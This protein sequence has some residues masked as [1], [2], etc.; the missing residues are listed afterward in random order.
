M[1]S[2]QYPTSGYHVQQERPEAPPSL[3][4]AVKLMYAGAVLSGLSFIIGLATTGRMRQA[5]IKASS[6]PLTNTQLHTAEVGGVVVIVIWGVLGVLL[7]LWM[8]SENGRG[9]SWS[10]IVAGFLF[11]FNTLD[12][13]FALIRPA[14]IGSKIFDILVWLVGLGATIYLRRPDATRY[15][16]QSKP[17]TEPGPSPPNFLPTDWH[18]QV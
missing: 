2:Q 16:Q 18:P 8:A 4:T 6:G 9:R 5:I 1:S 14:A 15:Y 11:G 12:L 17:F 3:R 7:W 13:L 10:R